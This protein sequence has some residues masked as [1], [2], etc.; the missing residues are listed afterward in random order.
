MTGLSAAIKVRA[1]RSLS[2]FLRAAWPH[3]DSA[4]FVSNWHLEAIAEHLEAV[5]DG[6][7]KR[8]LINIPP[9]FG[10]TNLVA[11]AWPVWIWC[12]PPD[13]DNPLIGPGATFLCASYGAKKA[14]QDGV[15]AR[16]LIASNW[17]Q[18]LW[19]DRVAVAS[20]RDNQE[21]YDTTAGGSRI[22]TGIP[23]S[24][25]K[26]GMFRILDDPHKT[27]EIE[28][29]EVA[30]KIIRNY[31]EIWRTRSNDPSFGAEVI[32]MQRQGE[33][34]IS[35]HVLDDDEV[36]HLCLP[37]EYEPD[38][39][40]TTAL[41]CSD[42]RSREGELLWP[43]RFSQKWVD[44]EKTR[45]GPYAWA[46]QYQQA[47]MPR[48]GG[49]IQ[50]EWWQEWEPKESPPVNFILASL[51][52][53]VRDKEESDYYA[54]TVWIVWSD[55]DTGAPKLLML[56]AWRRRGS[57][58]DIVQEVVATC[59]KF[60]VDCL[61]IED[62]AHGWA[63]QQEIL[64]MAGGWRFNIAMFD[65]RR[66][67]DKSARLLSVQPLFS[68][69]LVYAP[70]AADEHGNVNWR[71]WAEEVINEVTLFPRAKN[72]DYTDSVSMALRYLRDTGFALRKEEFAEDERKSLMH[73]PR[74]VS[75]LPYAV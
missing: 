62:K 46:A 20:D 74:A 56:N 60:K 25:G 45:I 4:P 12:Q 65:P 47:P 15:T 27:D 54:L 59:R 3:F 34:D 71:K 8:L 14:M 51:D 23:E 55:A 41:G 28:S 40:C 18:T 37:A 38:R 68:Q 32:I 29:A 66:Y 13:P 36:V 10:K 64:R 67:G 6:E 35:G 72:D 11:V 43:E 53:A 17:F 30:K 24:L 5:A 44:R 50:R 2:Y 22:N 61:L 73:K 1:E 16:R 39:H 9:R 48:G 69:G 58:H 70:V 31:D 26:G 21:R 57:L 42:P 33:N 63:A 7:I 75:A 52:T 49:I 19:G